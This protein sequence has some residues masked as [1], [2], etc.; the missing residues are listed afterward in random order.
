MLFPSDCARES[1]IP[2]DESQQ[3]SYGQKFFDKLNGEYPDVKVVYK[4]RINRQKLHELL[5]S[6]AENS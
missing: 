1:D 6:A 5:K 2:E 3:T 4:T